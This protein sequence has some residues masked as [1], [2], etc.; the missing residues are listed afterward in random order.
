M[1]DQKVFV[2]DAEGKPCLPTCSA[3]SRILLRKGKAK[4]VQVVPFTIQLNRVIDNPVG[5]FIVGVDD[6]AK[7][8]GIAIVNEHTKEVVFKGEIELRQ[9]VKRKMQQRMFYRRTR[10]S[11]NLRH[12]KAR[13]LNRK[14]MMPPLS[15]RQRKDSIIRFL[16]DMMKRIKIT[17]AIIEEGQFDISSMAAGRQ[18]YGREYQIPDYKGKNFR[19]KVLWRDKYTCQ[20]CPAKEDLRAHHI[21]PRK[22]GGSNSPQNGIT[23]CNICHDALHHKEWT[24]LSKPKRFIYPIWLMQGKNYLLKNLRIIGMKVQTCAGWMTAYWRKNLE[25]DKSH[26]NDAMAMICKDYI[27]L[28]NSFDWLIKPKRSKVWENNPTKTCEEKNGFKHYDLIKAY[29]RTKGVVIGSVRSLKK[30]AIMLRTKFDDNFPVSYRKS[31]LLQRFTGQIY[32]FEYICSQ[33]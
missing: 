33:S 21:I 20:H 28:V 17:K 13:F 4:V 2:I 12:R 15:I 3:R 22:D 9:D 30:N 25:M 5:E 23:L 14:Q 18:L 29:H 24:L 19:A 10:R 26:S 27:P 1:P 31:K 6:G 16:K 8:V 7:K 32:S 11:R